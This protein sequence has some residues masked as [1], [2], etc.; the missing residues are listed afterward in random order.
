MSCIIIDDPLNT[1]VKPVK[2][3]YNT[4]GVRFIYGHNLEKVYTYRIRKGAKVHLGQELVAPTPDGSRVVVA[5]RI[6]K[7][8]TDDG[9]Y[10]YKFI[11][12]KVGEL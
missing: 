11:E 5:V 8:P 6:D 9:P 7:K 12:Q 1:K 10:A 3:D 2:K 4:I